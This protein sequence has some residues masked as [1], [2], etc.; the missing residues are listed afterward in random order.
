MSPFL[1]S[2]MSVHRVWIRLSD[3]GQK[4]GKFVDMYDASSGQGF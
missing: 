4:D 2:E 3:Y 1:Q